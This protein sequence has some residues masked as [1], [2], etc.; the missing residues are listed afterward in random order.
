MLYSYFES[1]PIVYAEGYGWSL[2][3]SNLPFAALLIG[4][5]ISYAGYALWNKF[6]FE[7][8][9]HDTGHKIAPESR[10]PMSMVAAFCFPISLFWFA[11]SSNRTH[12]IV[13]VIA[14]SFFGMGITWMFLPF[15]TYLPD[16][17][18]RSRL[19]AILPSR[20]W[21]PPT[22]QVILNLEWKSANI[23]VP[24]IRSFSLGFKR[25][26]PFNDG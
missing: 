12:W 23:S 22:D 8:K 9:Y 16:G 1:F 24:R 11:W 26:L 21:I 17:E 20:S 19:D 7:K 2:G 6:Y 4:S 5:L 10:L 13:P 18:Y 15:L 25:F 14:S 3:I